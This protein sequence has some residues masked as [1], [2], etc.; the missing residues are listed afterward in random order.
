MTNTQWVKTLTMIII[1]ELW[2]GILI[3]IPKNVY[4]NTWYLA[5]IWFTLFPVYRYGQRYALT[6]IKEDDN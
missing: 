1:Y 4:D 6:F 5:A 3:A 2:S